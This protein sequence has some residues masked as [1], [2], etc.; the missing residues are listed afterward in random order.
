MIKIVLRVQGMMCPHCEARV[1]KAV[2]DA[3]ACE[4]VVSSH[5]KGTTEA[6]CPDYADPAAV[7]AAVEGAGYTVTGVTVRKKGLFGLWV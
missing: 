4:S 2:Q 5:K 3:C 7:K 6:I 1:T